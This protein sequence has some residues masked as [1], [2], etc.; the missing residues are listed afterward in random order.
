MVQA[1]NLPHFA[2]VLK[3]GGE[4]LFKTD[5]PDYF[6]AAMECLAEASFFQ[7]LIWEE[8]MFYPQTDFEELWMGQGKPI[9]RARFKKIG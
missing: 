3:P 1:S 8:E 4:F 9:H 7:P 5:H 2:R 6:E